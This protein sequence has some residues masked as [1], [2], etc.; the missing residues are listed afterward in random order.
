MVTDPIA[1]FITRLRNAGAVRKESISVPYSK[2]KFEVA[3]KLVEHGYITS[4]SKHGKKVKKIM[5]VEL[6]YP[7]RG[8]DKKSAS[9][10]TG[11]ER[12]SKP[13]RRVYGKVG[14]L[15]PVKGGR[16]A[17]VLS[18]PKGILTDNEA[19]KENVGGEV[20]FKIY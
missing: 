8:T 9:R 7:S 10:I 1:D 19:R 16:G 20:L 3:E 18:T 2:I 11:I 4:V 17:L 13:G 5:H 12:V 14:E 6:C 15:K